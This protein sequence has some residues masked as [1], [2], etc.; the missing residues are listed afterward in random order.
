MSFGLT[1][2]WRR[3]ICGMPSTRPKRAI[4]LCE[5]LQFWEL[6]GLALLFHATHAPAIGIHLSCV[7]L[8][9]AD[10]IFE[11]AV[12][13]DHHALACAY[14]CVTLHDTVRKLASCL[15]ASGGKAIFDRDEVFATVAGFAAEV[16][17]LRVD[18]CRCFS[19][20]RNLAA[21]AA[22]PDTMPLGTVCDWVWHSCRRSAGEGYDFRCNSFGGEGA[23]SSEKNSNT[24]RSAPRRACPHCCLDYKIVYSP[25]FITVSSIAC[26]TS[27]A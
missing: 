9:G 21:L 4:I 15:Q 7:G 16:G 27:A 22:R 14:F 24:N 26:R 5:L 13:Q 11:E 10:F 1:F 18:R 3:L 19:F 8:P 25:L 6:C 12:K 17:L 2:A 23:E 20:G